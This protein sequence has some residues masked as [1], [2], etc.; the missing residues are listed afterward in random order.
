M[1]NVNRESNEFS[2]E[3][4][5]VRRKIDFGAFGGWIFFIILTIYGLWDKI[6]EVVLPYISGYDFYNDAVAIGI[7]FYHGILT[8]IFVSSTFKCARAVWRLGTWEVEDEEQW[9]RVSER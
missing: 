8:L 1:Q 5:T 3:G 4:V 6:L 2:Q 7:P 9:R